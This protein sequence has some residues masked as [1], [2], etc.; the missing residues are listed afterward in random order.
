MI[1]LDL[2]SDHAITY[3]SSISDIISR[4]ENAPSENAWAVVDQLR[5]GRKP[6]VFWKRVSNVYG[7]G[8]QEMVNHC[9]L[10]LRRI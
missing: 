2:V 1:D 9:H 10:L 8:F 4:H 5:D 3:V 7:Y 6:S